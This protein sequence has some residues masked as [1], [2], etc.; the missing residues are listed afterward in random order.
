MVKGNLI[1]GQCNKISSF[2]S[3]NK[4]HV[5]FEEISMRRPRALIVC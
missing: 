4:Q 5:C 1:Y 2:L 3:K